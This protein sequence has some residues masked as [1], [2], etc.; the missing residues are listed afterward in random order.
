MHASRK[1]IGLASQCLGVFVACLVLAHGSHAGA[2][3]AE[4]AGKILEVTIEGNQRVSTDRIVARMRLKAGSDFS[5]DQADEDLKRI[6][7]LGSFDNVIIEP[8]Q[9]PA[10]IKLRVR[11]FER[12][13]MERVEFIGNI[14]FSSDKLMRETLLAPGD[15]INRHLIIVAADKIEEL[16]SKAGYFSASV[17]LDDRALD[18]ERVA[19]FT[20]V[21]GPRLR[22]KQIRFVGNAS[23]GTAKLG[24]M[25]VT[26][27]YKWILSPGVYRPEALEED[28]TRIA[29][30]YRQQGFL[31]VKVSRKLAFND[32][33]TRV[34]ITIIVEEGLRYHLRSVAFEGVKRF[35]RAYLAK[36]LSLQ[37]TEPYSVD[38]LRNDL[39]IISETYGEVGFINAVVEP[40]IDFAAQPGTLDI[41]FKIDEGKPI[42]IGVIRIVGNRVTQDKVIRREL[43]FFPE[44]NFNVKNI[45]LTERRLLETGLFDREKGVHIT[46]LPTPDPLVRDILVTITETETARVFFGAGVSSDLGLLGSLGY[47][48]RNFDLFDWPEN[49]REFWRGE[50]FK[51]AGQT[52]RIILEPG[53]ELQ[54]YHI[55]FVEPYLLDRDLS[56]SLSA[57][58][59]TWDREIYDEIHGGVRGSI[60]KRLSK[61][62]RG[63]IDVRLE[64]ID[65]ADV[66]LIAPT[67]VTSVKGA[68]FLSSVG[69]TVE[70]DMRDSRSAPSTGT[71]FTASLEQAG[72]L[73]GDYTF[74]KLVLDGRKYWTVMEDVAR[75][76]SVLAVRGQL[77]VMSDDAPIFERFYA[78]GHGSIRGFEYRG[79]GPHKAG[80]PVGGDFMLL[81][82]GEYSFP[83]YAKTLKGFVF[84]DTGTVGSSGAADLRAAIGF[85]IRFQLPIFGYVPF[86]LAFGL[87]IASVTGDDE[88]I[89]S[90][91]IGRPF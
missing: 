14:H 61:H 10:G 73:G 89:F 11:V 83:I 13:V 71:Y 79:A 64:S 69:L 52:L 80:E 8:I 76:K 51:G 77:G 28:L 15:L 54:R 34:T 29:A 67:D 85:G 46:S 72:V 58:F 9:V 24:R 81:A 75:G 86:D 25:M 49:S 66:S 19:R 63:T 70:R 55:N 60:G 57:Y 35:S 23:V 31:D 91:T 33:K 5:R 82:S 32:P 6:W 59:E 37:P 38:R 20:I 30:Y 56:L 48:E 17:V 50:A 47:T 18:T 41:T 22:I 68:S 78:G 40:Q 36:Q 87:P 26:K 27:R 4:P 3:E 21:E 90:F 12:P 2:Q 7:A 88:Q 84:L 1:T 42:R 16:Y 74:S 65:I 39:K 53:T 45:R 43:L 44:Q 62:W